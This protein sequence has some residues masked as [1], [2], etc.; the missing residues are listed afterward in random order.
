MPL[1]RR[2]F[3]QGT[4]GA[5]GAI[6][7]SQLGLTRSA[8]RYGQVLAQDTPRKVALLVGIND[9]PN[10]LS[11][12]GP[13]TD[14]ELQ[15]QLLIHRFG[16]EPSD[17]H[18]L[19]NQDASRQNILAAFQQ[20]LYEPARANDVI[21]LHF[22]GHGDRVRESDRMENFL[23]QLNRRCIVDGECF[24]TAIATHSTT[25]TQDIMGHTLLLMRAALAQK[26]KNVTFLLDCC[27]A[28]G[29]RR[30]NAMMRSL[31]T[32]LGDHDN[33]RQIPDSEWDYQQQLLDILQWD[34]QKFVDAI[35]SPKGQGFFVG[36]A[37]YNQLAADYE[38]DGFTAGAFTYL[39][40]Q[41]LWQ[42]TEPLSKTISLV[43]NS[44]NY[45]AEHSQTPIYDPTPEA[46]PAVTHTPIYH[47]E[48]VALP[49]EALV[50]GPVSDKSN[51]DRVKL[52]LGGLDPW[53]LDAF[54]QGATFA[55]IDK[56]TGTELAEVQQVDG[57]RNGLVSE[58]RLSNS[59]QGIRAANVTTQLLQEKVRGIPAQV[60]LK[61]GLDDTLLASEQLTATNKLARLANIEVV[62]VTAGQVA[63]VLL[64]RYTPAIHQRLALTPETAQQQQTLGSVGIFSPAQVPLLAGSFGEA[65]EPMDRAIDRLSNRLVSLYIG[66]MLALM[67]NQQSSR[68]DVS[69]VVDYLDFRSG[70]TTRGGDP[71]AI[72]IPRTVGGVLQ[73]VDGHRIKVT[74][75]NNE[76]Q[77]LHVGVI[78]I[79]AAGEVN[80]LFPPAASDRNEVDIIAQHSSWS[81]QLQG[82]PPFGM[83]ELL[84]L[85]SPKSLVGALKKLR[86]NLPQLDRSLRTGQALA[87]VDAM[88]DIFGVMSTQRGGNDATQNTRLLEAEQ[89]AI[90]SMFV[91]ILP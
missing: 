69:L 6:G 61:V 80:V 9:Y 24:N 74:V 47:M 66:R 84:V 86:Q 15:R 91:E 64:G 50:L 40:T 75:N 72:I 19:Q 90:L 63:H 45:L 81:T 83:A 65:G 51:H 14:I 56:T 26:T 89:V 53:A 41:H 60:T 20:Y 76:S 87:N 8:N 16:F 58:G 67:V 36:S 62:P 30:G 27:Y 34:S 37:R 13:L 39:L 31:N 44:S 57:S 22:S 12:R 55:L 23:R 88:D 59:T 48:P 3:L 82:A 2:H 49:A 71:E 85:V 29:G 17:I 38:F 28:G 42:S 18:I 11:L 1:T 52:W 32:A 4:A 10:N 46:D 43:S 7:L 70:T 35:Q 78:V 33:L 77:D 79:D 5:L 25:T 21:I 54:D 73:I 68:L